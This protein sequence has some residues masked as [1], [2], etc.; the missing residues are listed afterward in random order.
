MLYLIGSGTQVLVLRLKQEGLTLSLSL[1]VH[2]QLCLLKRT[3]DSTKLM[4]LAVQLT[5]PLPLQ[6]QHPARKISVYMITAIQK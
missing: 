5:S 1:L 4:S 6:Q 3:E 2:F